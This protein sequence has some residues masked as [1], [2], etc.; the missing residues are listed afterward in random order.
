MA[1]NRMLN[2]E[3]RAYNVTEKPVLKDLKSKAPEG[4]GP[5]SSP[6]K[7]PTK[8]PPSKNKGKNR[9]LGVEIAEGVEEVERVDVVTTRGRRVQKPRRFDL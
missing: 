8:M 5:S 2:A 6:M 4:R 1:E 3:L 7:S 9:Q